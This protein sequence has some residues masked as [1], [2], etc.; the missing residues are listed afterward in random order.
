MTASLFGLDGKKALIVGGGRGMGESSALLLAQAGCDVAVL[1][2]DAGRAGHVADAVRGCGRQGFPIVADILDEA[3]VR[4]AVDEAEAALGGIDVLVTI[5]GQALFK[6]LLDVT[7]EE[8]DFDQ[9]RNLRYFFVTARAVAAAMIARGQ[10]GALVCVGSV[11]GAIG[12]PGHAAYGAA[13]AG[14][15]HLVKSMAGEWGRS[16]IRVNAV[17]PGSITTPRLP[18]TDQSRALMEA[19]VLPIGRAGTTDEVAGA[20]LFLAS[21]LAGYVT[22]HTVFVDGGWMAANLFDPRVM[23]VKKSNE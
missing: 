13:K 9:S 7:L 11:D 12:A 14:L 15:M 1:D 8:W 19:S 3:S 23:A 6:P 10:G 22:G 2:N 18:E 21:K 16:G 4:R 5:V 17:A 20:V